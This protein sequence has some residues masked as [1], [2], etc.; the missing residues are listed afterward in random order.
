MQSFFFKLELLTWPFIGSVLG[1][2]PPILPL[3]L[4]FHPFR[5]FALNML[6][7]QWRTLQK[8]VAAA[9]QVEARKRKPRLELPTTRNLF[10]CS[11][12]RESPVWLPFPWNGLSGGQELGL[13]RFL[14]AA[15]LQRCHSVAETFL[16]TMLYGFHLCCSVADYTLII[17]QII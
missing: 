2:F 4:P 15:D 17:I 5:P 7:W 1:L 13:E 3:A 16:C 14:G 9:T 11:S 10:P 8:M 6:C 12:S